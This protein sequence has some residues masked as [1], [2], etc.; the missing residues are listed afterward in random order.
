MEMELENIFLK[1]D[2]THDQFETFRERFTL[3]Q[4]RTGDSVFTE[5]DLAE[6]FYFIRS[7]E[8]TV[9]RLSSDRQEKVLNLLGPGELFGEV[10]LLQDAPR[11]ATIKAITDAQLYELRKADFIELLE[12]D[13]AF[14]ALLDRLRTQRLL[15][16]IPV[17]RKLDDEALL[18]IRK[19]LTLKHYQAGETLVSEG[20][21]QDALYL[22][23]K[24][25]ART[26]TTG[27]EGSEITTGFMRPGSYVGARGLTHRHN[28]EYSV[29]IEDSADVFV[30]DKKRF[31]RLLRRYPGISFS[32]PESGWLNTLLPFF[33]GR[34][35]Y[36]T[37]PTLAMNRP[38]KVNWITGIITLV[39][40]L[41]AA[42]PTLFPAW[43]PFLHPLVVDTDPENMLAAEEP[44]RVF[45]DRMKAEMTLHDIMVVGV[46]NEKHPDGVF[47]ASSLGRV[48]ELSEFA[49]TLTWED[50]ERP[51][52]IVGVLGADMMSPS[53]MDVVEQAG[54][55]AVRFSWLMPKPPASDAEAMEIYRKLK[56]YPTMDGT[57]ISEDGRAISIYV[58]LTS[59]DISFRV[60][61]ALKEFIAK[62]EGDEQYFI[63]GLP[64]AED[65]FG[66]E[67]FIQMA[68]SAPAAMLVIFLLM[69]YFFRNL[70]VVISSMLVAMVS[71]LCTMALLVI[72]G[73]TLH[74]MSSMIPIFVMPIAVLD[75]IHI[76]S[77]F[78]DTYP[79]I[80]DRRMTMDHVMRDLFTPMLYTSLTTAVGF[81]SLSLVPIPPVQVFGIFVS[82]GVTLAFLLSISFV[83][84]F[85]MLIPKEK[86]ELLAAAGTNSR[87]TPSGKTGDWLQRTRIFALG[88]SRGVIG[89]TLLVVL[90]CL[91]G[92][93]RIVV[94]DNPV[95]WFAD[96]HPIRV[97]DK[98]LNDHFAGTYMAYLALEA[99]DLESE[100][101]VILDRL[102]DRLNNFSGDAHE[103]Q[104]R[105]WGFISSAREL[106]LEKKSPDELLLE[107][108]A[109][110]ESAIDAGPDDAVIFWEEA[111]SAIETLRHERQYFKDP[112]VLAYISELQEAL[113]ATGIVGKSISIADI[114]MTVN[115]E[116]RGGRSEDYRIPD[117]AQ[118]VAQTYL[119]SQSGHRP[120]DMWRFVTPDYRKASIWL[121]LNSGDNVDMAN[122]VEAVEDYIHRNPPPVPLATGWFGLTYINVI[123]QEKM[124]SGMLDSIAGGY[125]AVLLLMVFLLRSTLWGIL[126][127][128]PLTC[129]MLV[130][131]GVLGLAGK[132][133]DMP[134]AVLSSLSIGLAVDFT[135]HFLVRIRHVMSQTGS[136]QRAMEIMFTEPVRAIL[137]NMLVVAVGFL[138]LL[139]APLVPYNTVG[140]L[141]AVILITSGVMTILILPAILKTWENRFFPMRD[142]RRTTSFSCGDALIMGMTGM[143]FVA[144][145]FHSF[146]PWEGANLPWFLLAVS[147]PLL[148]SLYCCRRIRTNRGE[149]PGGVPRG[150]TEGTAE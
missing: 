109:L 43:L 136:W 30:L 124:V 54:E 148:Y 79:R 140:T 13:P 8:L 128:V 67:M 111:L 103:L 99:T 20:D 94:N 37:I 146:L 29:V 2:L 21:A 9:S 87:A 145:S 1:Y 56:R 77:E 106:L 116:L 53:T 10:G 60:Y 139:V 38:G 15:Q 88:R 126:A 95:R 91:F 7:G 63:T 69:Y 59:K 42:T 150:V 76:L 58:P 113:A 125:L 24:G 83:P 81:A 121:L 16:G 129:T 123:W 92:V 119:T 144:V 115:R 122:V 133:Y 66:V 108:E 132:P 64:V 11:I 71:V 41:A 104:S 18:K 84:A 40:I 12:S 25:N 61:Q 3:R 28:H 102:Q 48:Y 47:N 143:V 147:A 107:L 14:S 51:G 57:L 80:R 90:L 26:Y 68:I 35:A 98:V 96:E 72:T 33:Y 137:R 36:L 75:S 49:K 86:F 117:T 85:V 65:S 82:I 5:G 46:V 27:P 93:Q 44:H 19:E 127:M 101:A 131:Y 50:E 141:I 110:A 134:V 105:T 120:Q 55:G 138:P 142:S 130:I 100:P 70:T 114:S 6:T 89:I 135:I 74:I 17:F 118:G 34:E 97:A 45:H 23:L 112:Q 31:R 62:Q 4:F 149:L 73:N 39:L 78:F 52:E 22:I 32:I